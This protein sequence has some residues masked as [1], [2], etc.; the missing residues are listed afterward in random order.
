MQRGLN[1]LLGQR[2]L[3]MGED[4]AHRILLDQLTVAND[5]HAVAD[6]FHHIHFVGDQQ[7]GQSQTPVNV[8]QQ[9]ENGTGG[10]RVEGAG[11][12]IAQQYLRVAGQR[13]GNSDALFLATGEISRVAVVLITQAD[14]IQ[15]LRHTA[16]D[17]SLRGVIQFQ[18]QRHVAENG[19][20]SQQVKMLENHAN[21]T[22]RAG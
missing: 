6:A 9:F 20:G 16:F 12:F 18:G 4:F 17:F 8:F 15:Q 10:G 3:R 2:R 19:P 14:E 1:K 11:G 21:L 7:N 13:A 5:R 22:A